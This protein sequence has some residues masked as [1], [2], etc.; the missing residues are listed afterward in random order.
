MLLSD[1]DRQGLDLQI[2]TGS[3][4]LFYLDFANFR[5]AING[6]ASL[7]SETFTVYGSSRLGDIVISQSTISSTNATTFRWHRPSS[8]QTNRSSW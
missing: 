2:T 7:A 8:L 6:D 3:N 4:P 1:L 5:A